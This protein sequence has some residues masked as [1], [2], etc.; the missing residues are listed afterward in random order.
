MGSNPLAAT[1]LFA[2]LPNILGFG[3]SNIR[4]SAAFCRSFASLFE[5]NLRLSTD[6]SVTE[7]KLPLKTPLMRE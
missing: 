7:G 3:H 6:R 2:V 1:D 4:T 5:T